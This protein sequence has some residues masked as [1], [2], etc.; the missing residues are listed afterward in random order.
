M[1]ASSLFALILSGIILQVGVVLA[2]AF[3]RRRRAYAVLERRMADG[4]TDTAPARPP[5]SAP[6]LAAWSDFR[7]FRVR[8]KH[9]EDRAQSV[10]SFVLEPADGGAVPAFAPG[11]F[12]TFRLT[13][14]DPTTGQSKSIVRCYSLS[15]CPGGDT[16]RVSIKRVPAPAGRD[17]LPPGLASNH[18]HDH[19]LEGGLLDVKA[20]SGHFHLDPKAVGPV[21]LVAGGIGVTPMISMAAACLHENPEREVWFFYGVRDG[22]DEAFAAPLREWE[23]K[24]PA[25]HLH[26]CHSRPA[27]DE[28]NGRDYHHRG[29]VDLALLRQVLPL[30]SFDY[31][32]CGPRAMMEALVPALLE[33]GVPTDRIHY[34]AFGPASLPKLEPSGQ[35]VTHKLTPPSQP[36]SVTF[37]RSGRQATWTGGSLL[38]LAE[39]N[40]IAVDCGCRAGGCGM[41]QTRVEQGEVEYEHSPDFDAEPGTC[42]LCVG[43]P[44]TNLVLTA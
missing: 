14:A 13:V 28:G 33:W 25:F 30:R 2:V 17:D 36:L 16:Y 39:A 43:H 20:P 15:D 23:K 4:Q 26:V 29:H 21:V 9:F 7:P 41:C 5:V 3:V 12:L 18:F 34:E 32:V 35:D 37:S 1:T 10:C 38:E 22:S 19:V 40:D 44:K 8:S 6:S 42:L 31:Y 24:H 11:Q 27:A